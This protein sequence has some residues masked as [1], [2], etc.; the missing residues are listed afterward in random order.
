M[1]RNNEWRVESVCSRFMV[2][3]H[4]KLEGAK[5]FLVNIDDVIESL[6][7]SRLNNLPGAL[8]VESTKHKR[9]KTYLAQN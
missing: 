7:W 4:Q 9:E 3:R 8:P 1:P 6:I 2:P 5:E